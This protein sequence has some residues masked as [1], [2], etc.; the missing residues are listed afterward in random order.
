MQQQ[1]GNR[2]LLEMRTGFVGRGTSFSRWCT[3]NGIKRQNARAAVLG[4]WTGPKARKVVLALS[5][6][7]GL[8]TKGEAR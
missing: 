5:A 6:A 7:A 8:P 3:E 2:L 1:D 4:E